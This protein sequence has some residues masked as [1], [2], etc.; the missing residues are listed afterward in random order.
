M[1]SIKRVAVRVV[2]VL[3]MVVGLQA[4]VR[5]CYEKWSAQTVQSKLERKQ[6]KG[7]IDTLYCGTSL[8][9]Y[10]FDPELLDEEL[11][12]SSFNL[13]TSAQPY[14][15][16]YYLIRE[17]VEANP[18]KQI[19]LTISLPQLL[20]DEPG[21]ASYVSAFENMCSWKWKLAYLAAVGKEEV[22]TA[23][24]LYST[25]VE[26]YLAWNTVTSNLVNKLFIRQVPESYAGRGLRTSEAVFD[27]QKKKNNRNNIWDGEAGLEQVSSEAM[28]YLEKIADFCR[29]EGIA[30]TLVAL[31]H[32]Q[33]YTQQ[34]GD[35]DDF[36]TVFSEKAQ[37][38]GAKFYDFNLYKDRLTV[39]TD[40]K[41]ADDHHLNVAGGKTF[42]QILA[43]VVM[44]DDPQEYFYESMVQFHSQE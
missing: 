27:G 28:C 8:T 33:V 35:L 4:L 19:Y 16:T 29:E 37:E 2:L 42:S 6:L 22:W 10:G 11:G 18:V 3:L 17:T 14:I 20:R 15:G 25:Q 13:G 41:F 9:Y 32:S 34:A 12:T 26:S 5:L 23:C 36:H 31:P 24:L 21:T 38:W 39:F 40:D 43:Q 1:H 44:S 30:L 7:T